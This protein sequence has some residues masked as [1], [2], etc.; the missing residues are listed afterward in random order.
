MQQFI[1]KLSTEWTLDT[2]SF[3]PSPALLLSNQHICQSDF[4]EFANGTLH[5]VYTQCEHK[6]WV[7]SIWG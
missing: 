2:S 7:L 5:A 4:I 6:D 1:Q 3:A